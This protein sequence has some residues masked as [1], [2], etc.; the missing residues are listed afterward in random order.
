VRELRNVVERAMIIAESDA[1]GKSDLALPFD[2]FAGAGP[3]PADGEVAPL[4]LEEMEKRHV[5]HVL[6]RAGGSKTRAAA[7]LGVSRSTL[8]E[9]LKRYSID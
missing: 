9:K 3:S 2:G 8:W 1:I 4:S 6:E 7:M 5:A